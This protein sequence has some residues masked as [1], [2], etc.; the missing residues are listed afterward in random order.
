M[1][2]ELGDFMRRFTRN[3]REK[4]GGI[5]PE[6]IVLTQYTIYERPRD[7]PE[8]YVVRAFHIVRGQTEPLPD[9]GSW[10]VATLEL[11]RAV[12]PEGLVNIGRQPGDD[13]H[14]LEVWT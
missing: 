5:P 11:A 13:I 6:A 8:G 7:Y 10:K 9:P 12:I 4:L 2:D 14:I 1:S 3:A